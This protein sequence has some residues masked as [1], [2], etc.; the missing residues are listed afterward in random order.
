MAFRGGHEFC[1]ARRHDFFDLDTGEHFRLSCGSLACPYC[2]ESQVWRAGVALSHVQPERYAVFS[3]VQDTWQELRAAVN[4]FHQ[5]LD[6]D[7]YAWHDVYTAEA[8]G[9]T[10][11]LHLN[12]WQHGDYVPQPYLVEAAQRVG[13]GKIVDIRKWVS[14]PV[15][16]YGLKE[17]SG[18][19]YGLKEACAG[20]DAPGGV[21]ALSGS[22]TATQ[23]AFLARNGGRL[24]HGRNSFWRDGSGGET[25]GSRARVFERAMVKRRGPKVV[26]EEW[27]VLA[28]SEL[29]ASSP[30]P[31]RVRVTQTGL[32]GVSTTAGQQQP[33][34]R[35]ASG[36]SQLCLD[37]PGF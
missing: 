21:S 17:A 11:M 18:I 36:Q 14:R 7:R 23:T 4:R 32:T 37:F 35:V 19:V 28:G 13:W 3:N 25:L 5:I 26:R 9:Q 16:R 2:I 34:S 1:P 8:G 31:R 6:R 12:M 24:L 10:G 20:E 29:V 33:G 15:D 27:A 22:L 30:A